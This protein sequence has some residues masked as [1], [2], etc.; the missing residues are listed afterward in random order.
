MNSIDLI[1]TEIMSL[2]KT[3]PRIHVNISLGN[4]NINIHNTPAVIKAVYPHVFRLEY[5]SA[6]SSGCLT[7]QYIDVLTR[8]IEIM[9]L[10][11][12]MP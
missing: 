9:E 7:F 10:A 1:K 8:N 5:C 6:A 2:Y 12:S 4:P 11:S 3:N